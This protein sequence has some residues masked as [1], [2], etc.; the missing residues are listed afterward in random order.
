MV[1]KNLEV[2]NIIF[3]VKKVDKLIKEVNLFD[4]Y[5]GKNIDGD[6][7]SVAFAVKIQPEQNLT[8]EEI[9][10]ISNKIIKEIES[11]FEGILRK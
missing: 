4:I 11:K 8:T 7:K 6:K 3:S 1:D 10:N 5:I 2:G 9:D